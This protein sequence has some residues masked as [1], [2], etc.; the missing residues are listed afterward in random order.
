M[1]GYSTV[2]NNLG[3]SAYPCGASPKRCLKEIHFSIPTVH[4]SRWRKLILCPTVDSHLRKS[5]ESHPF[6][7]LGTYDIHEAR[8]AKTL[9]VCCF[10]AGCKFY[11]PICWAI[12]IRTSR[13]SCLNCEKSL[14]KSLTF[15]FRNSGRLLM[16]PPFLSPNTEE[17]VSRT[18][19]LVSEFHW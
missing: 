19:F 11:L 2:I 12:G 4:V 14:I 1:Q 7:L 16:V 18:Q 3:K 6:H 15:N 10:C 9:G 13:A 17:V 8:W 5:V